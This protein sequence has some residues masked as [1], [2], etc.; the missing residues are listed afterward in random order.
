[1]LVAAWYHEI[2]LVYPHS[3]TASNLTR[4]D[5]LYFAVTVF[6]TVGFGDITASS[7]LTPVLVTIQ[8]VLDLV[9][10]GLG[11]RI[12]TR[13]LKVGAARHGAADPQS[14]D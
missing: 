1:M 12:L 13:A 8:M 9:I 11:I 7:Q 4:T 14:L 2:S 3:F 6:S 10:L 5:A